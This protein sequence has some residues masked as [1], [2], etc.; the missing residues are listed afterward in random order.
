MILL[1]LLVSQNVI[2]ELEA[3]AIEEE[4]KSSASPLDEILSEHN[5]PEA[6]VLT[7][8]NALYGIPVYNGSR[9]LAD[10]ELY[11]L[12]DK[13]KSERYLAVPLGLRMLDEG[14]DKKVIERYEEAKQEKDFIKHKTIADEVLIGV[15]DPE[16]KNVLDALQFILTSA[17]V[18]YKIYLI[19]LGEF[20]RRFVGYSPDGGEIVPQYARKRGDNSDIREDII[21]ITDEDDTLLE[22]LV[23]SIPM[24]K[25]VNIILKNSIM[26]LASDIHI[27]NVGDR[28]RIRTRVDGV[29]A[30]KFNIPISRH[31][32][33]VARIKI[34]CALK[35]DEKRKPQDGRFSVRYDG[36][37]ID[38]RVSTFPS[39]YGEKV[40]LRILDSYRGV[41]K[42]EDIGFS[43]D[44]LIKIRRA[45]SKP[46][47][48]VL[49]SGPTGSGKTTTLYSMLNEVDR[50]KRNVVSLEDPIEYNI[51]SMSQSQ[52][53]PEIGYTF[54]NG[55]RSILR[56]DPD[57]IMVGEI[58]DAETAQL[59]IQAA[60]TGHLVFS[61]IHT[62]NAI[63][64]ITRLLD[65]GV[66]PY[67]I[68]PTLN[69][70]IAQR[71]VR[72]IDKDAGEELTDPGV[73]ALI[74]N[75][76]KDLPEEFKKKLPL[77]GH[78]YNAV[79]TSTNPSGLKGRAP[80]FEMLEVDHE[81]E[82]LILAKRSEDDIRDAARKKG[83]IDMKEDA[84]IKSLEGLVP[85]TEVEGL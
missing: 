21:D 77:E 4:M 53:F 66:D 50:E 71:L 55:L 84:I 9:D 17:G 25:M 76:F 14:T 63:G 10:K 73:R 70:A 27:E 28:V 22:S 79:P 62:N 37:K 61:T 32:A 6:A 48:I 24:M 39:Y 13:D 5:V 30:T 65:M 80:A 78:P 60:L 56:Q 38:F 54:A 3:R 82:N 15:V 16:R 36:H 58:R 20:K 46:Y 43:K 85:F 34:L 12:F 35:L 44:H 83:F 18:A 74:D 19:S 47:G 1:N 40:V 49:I 57:V 67:L 26:S 23:D 81:I 72:K 75:K 51:P 2:S 64:V 68:A 52:I 29:L 45:L 31:S 69:L 42:I 11:T 41:K 7:A 8:R 33:I 59:A